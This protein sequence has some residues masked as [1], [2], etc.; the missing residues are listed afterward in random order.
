[1]LDKLIAWAE[2]AVKELEELDAAFHAAYG[3]VDAWIHSQL[4]AAKATLARLKGESLPEGTFGADGD[5]EQ[6]MATVKGE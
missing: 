3:R 1:M 6:L 4:E 2:A 5:L